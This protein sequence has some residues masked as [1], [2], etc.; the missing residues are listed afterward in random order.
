MKSLRFLDRRAGYSLASLGL[1]LGIVVPSVV[2]A[3]ASAA[4]VADRSVTLSDSSASA[5]GVSYEF[6][7]TPTQAAGAVVVWFCKN[8]P[9]SGQACTAP[10]GMDASTAAISSTITNVPTPSA[11][12]KGA[13]YLKFTASLTTTPVDIAFDGIANPLPVRPTQPTL[14]TAV[15]P[16]ELP[17]AWAL[18]HTSWKA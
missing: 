12:S 15:W 18:M 10:P 1:L 17:K 6:K 8:T 4:Q 9:I 7:F 11:L 3:F 16:L 5:T 13:N 2:P 14:I